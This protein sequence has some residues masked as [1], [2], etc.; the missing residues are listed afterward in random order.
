MVRV[1]GGWTTLAEFLENNDPCRGKYY[2][3]LSN[4]FNMSSFTFLLCVT[5]VSCNIRIELFFKVC[6]IIVNTNVYMT[7]SPKFICEKTKERFK[8]QNMHVK[9]HC[10]YSVISPSLIYLNMCNTQVYVYI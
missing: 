9:T 2:E 3:D 6:H 7:L 1:G 8:T 4:H 10:L 5:Y